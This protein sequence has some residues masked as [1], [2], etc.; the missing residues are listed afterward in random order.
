MGVF[1]FLTGFNGVG[2]GD[3]L[4]LA[5]AWVFTGRH[6]LDFDS[7][8]SIRESLLCALEGREITESFDLFSK[9]PERLWGQ[10]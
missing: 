2:K 4:G 7:S 9:T 1:Y 3:W 10:E 5:I 8:A 6:D